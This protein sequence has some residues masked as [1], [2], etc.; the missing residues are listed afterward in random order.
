MLVTSY[1]AFRSR[2]LPEKWS[3]SH[4]VPLTPTVFTSHTVWCMPAQ[5]FVQKHPKALYAT[6]DLITPQS[7]LHQE[8]FYTTY[9]L[10]QKAFRSQTFHTDVLYT[11]GLFAT[12]T[13]YTR[14]YL[15]QKPFAL[16]LREGE[17]DFV[18]LKKDFW[19]K[20][21][22]NMD[23][24]NGS[25]L[26]HSPNVQKGGEIVTMG[27]YYNYPVLLEPPTTAIGSLSIRGM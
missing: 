11:K 15:H 18:S 22:L 27:V 26:W 16:H 10:H 23:L 9:P 19:H 7:F 12:C 4:Q 20:T 1:R 24:Q 13:I 6:R 5:F 17:Y 25:Q 21:S 3:G 2:V 14:P 8:T